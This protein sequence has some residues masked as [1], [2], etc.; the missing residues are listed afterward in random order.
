MAWGTDSFKKVTAEARKEMIA[1]VGAVSSEKITAASWATLP[2]SVQRWLERS[3]VSGNPPVR[4]VWL[5]QEA[6]MQ[7]KPGQS[8]WMDAR[9]E[10]T[11]TVDPP[12]FVWSVEMQMNPAMQIVGRDV[13]REGRGTMK[14][15]MN[16]IIPLVDAKGD[17]IDE[18]T[19]QRY[20][21][22][23]VWFPTAALDPRIRWEDAGPNAARATLKVGGTEGSGVFYF[24]ESGDMVRFEAMRYYGNE[25]G[26][27][28]YPWVITSNEFASPAGFRIP[29]D[30]E[31]TWRFDDQDWTWLHLRIESIAY[32]Y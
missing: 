25:A 1:K 32:E 27:R 3:G 2:L 21:G 30:M 4:T 7:M 18:G 5:T 8:K 17:Q 10:Q 23:T 28:R 16:G 6:S 29:V 22:E 9:A 15:R 31:A 13:F 11:F 20:L 12:G 19:L 14:I 26:S 24:N